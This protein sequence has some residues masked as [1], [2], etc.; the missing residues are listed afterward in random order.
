[1]QS[2][3]PSIEPPDR[4]IVGV[5]RRARLGG[6]LN[7]V[8]RRGVASSDAPTPSNPRPMPAEISVVDSAN[9]DEKA[10]EQLIRRRSSACTLRAQ[11]SGI[12]IISTSRRPN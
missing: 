5:E 12:T 7:Y 10:R 1:M 4:S 6:L 9:G 8:A 2:V 11:G 3:A